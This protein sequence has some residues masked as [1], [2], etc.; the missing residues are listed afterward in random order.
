[1]NVGKELKEFFKNIKIVIKEV[2]NT[3]E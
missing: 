3:Y 2:G 1:M